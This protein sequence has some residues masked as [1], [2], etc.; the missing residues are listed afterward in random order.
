MPKRLSATVD[1]RIAT[2]HRE[3]KTEAQIATV[4][5]REGAPLTA[6]GVHRALSRLGLAAPRK[7]AGKAPAS[8]VTAVPPAPES[9]RSLA[10]LSDESIADDDI[11]GRLRRA[12]ASL[13]R[14]A[15]QAEGDKDVARVVACQRAITQA[16]GL[17]AKATPPPA[18]DVDARPDMVTAAKRGRERMHTLLERLLGG[19]S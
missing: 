4:L 18:V 13:E 11:P 14:A 17:L 9:A 5:A 3:H 7:K 2:L 19:E 16:A 8:G 15:D 6:S 12:L 1:A 10:A